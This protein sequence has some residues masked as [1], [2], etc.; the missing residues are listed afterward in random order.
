MPQSISGVGIC[1]RAEHYAVFLND[2]KPPAPWLEILA[3]NYLTCTGIAW[4]KLCLITQNYPVV[5]HCVGLGIGNT[6]PIDWAYCKKI[7]A[8]ADKLKPAWI[9]DHLCWT[10]FENN[11]SHGLLPLLYTEET[12][13]HVVNRTKQL[14]DFFNIPLAFENIA[15]YLCAPKN[16]L[17]EAEFIQALCSQTHAGLLLDINNLY[18]NAYNH[19]FN[20]ISFLKKIPSKYVMQYHLAGHQQQ[21]E[22]LIDTHDSNVAPAVWSLFQSALAIIGNKPTCIEWDEQIPDFAWLQKESKKAEN[23]ASQRMASTIS[24]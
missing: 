17:S 13:Q 7:K 12:L 20:P 5:L 16:T 2:N 22:L 8:I 18:I 4:D 10:A 11:H 21:N 24:I 15:T 9:S 23:Y 6:D 1:L 19:H 14:Q 3:D